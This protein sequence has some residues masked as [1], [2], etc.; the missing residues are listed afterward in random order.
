MPTVVVINKRIV[1][2]T[3]QNNFPRWQRSQNLTKC[4][5]KTSATD[6]YNKK[7]AYQYRSLCLCVTLVEGEGRIISISNRD[8]LEMTNRK[9]KVSKYNVKC[10]C[11]ML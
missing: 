9:K 2:Q 11:K 8:E 5:I 6:Y 7:Q 10:K 4:R 1:Y 3:N